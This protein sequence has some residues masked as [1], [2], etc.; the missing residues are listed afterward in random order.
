[1]ERYDIRLGRTAV[2]R[3]LLELMQD[4]DNDIQ[5][6]YE[7]LR[8]LIPR[9]ET[10]WYKVIE[11][12]KEAIADYPK[13]HNGHKPSFRT[14][15]YQLIDEKVISDS[16]NDHN[17]LTQATVKARLGWKMLTVNCCIPS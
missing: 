9:E 15:Q 7:C 14:M 13:T 17:S 8:P 16:N 12:L 6:N 2:R 11:R 4:S 5:T 3:H 10:R 1:M